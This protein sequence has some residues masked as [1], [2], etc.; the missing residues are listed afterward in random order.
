MLGKHVKAKLVLQLR[1]IASVRVLHKTFAHML[2]GTHRAL[3]GGNQPEKQHGLRT[4]RRFEKHL[5][6]A[7]LFGDKFLPPTG[8]YGL[9]A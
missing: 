3:F 9:P 2:F 7:N 1:P 6:T 8:H 4:R 5:L